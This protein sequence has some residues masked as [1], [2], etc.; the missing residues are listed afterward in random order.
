MDK[1]NCP[2]CDE[3]LI[4]SKI[5][6]DRKHLYSSEYFYNTIGIDGS[7]IG[8]YDGIVAWRCPDCGHEWAR[9]NDDFWVC[10]FE[11]YRKLKED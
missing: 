9:G 11:K 3:N 7:H 6:D 4:H 1:T 2:H 10:V 8:V 5:P